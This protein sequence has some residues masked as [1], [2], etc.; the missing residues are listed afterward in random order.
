MKASLMMIALLL[1]SC[2]S[3]S[4]KRDVVLLS[5]IGTNDVHGGLDEQTGGL[6]AFSGY[7][8]ALRSQQDRVVVL[9][10]GGD[11][12]QGTLESNLNEGAAVMATYNALGYDAATI[13]NHEFD[14]GPVGDSAIPMS[15]RDDPRGALKARAA[16]A[17]FP[18][19][20]ANLIDASTQEPVDWPNV[21]P[22]QMLTK[23]GVRIGVIGITTAGT[24]TATI[25]ANTIGLLMAPLASTVER[26]AKALRAAG[27]DLVI[28]AA[29]AGG[30]CRAFDDPDDLSS[31]EAD[32]EIFELARVLPKGLVDQ[33]V[34]GH[35]HA[36]IAHI[37]NGVAI[38]S[39]RARLPSFGRVDYVL[40]KRTHQIL[41]RQVFPPQPVC[42]RWQEGS[43]TCAK[44]NDP[45][46]VAAAYEGIEIKALPA[47]TA[48]MADA[49]DFAKARKARRLGV[50]L[51][52]AFTRRGEPDAVIGHMMTDA[53]REATGADVAIHNVAGGIRADFEP[54]ELTFGDVYR[55]FPFDN[56]LAVLEL[57]GAELKRLLTHQ[58]HESGR[59]AGISGVRIE[60]VC[61]NGTMAL[62]LRKPDGNYVED[63]DKLRVAANDF[64]LL[65][66][67][68]IFK[69]I[70]PDEGYTIDFS[71]PRLRDVWVD[72]FEQR[73]GILRESD[74]HA[75][76]GSR[77]ALPQDYL[78]SCPR[79]D[80]SSH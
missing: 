79:P 13:G 6:A 64:L 56:L 20:A 34:A 25:S 58:V 73:G 3:L 48:A 57:N 16:E 44:G 4:P 75:S 62:S 74:F 22:S 63:D 29:H 41:S 54:G 19:L 27:A 35:H 67:G 53:I 2:T 37:V 77:W 1:A 76:G 39:N 49:I 51:E 47:V 78:T 40:D 10:D 9:L 5:I 46:T 36:G 66:G 11:M 55:V 72:W 24:L 80:N 65:G 45:S 28:V 14:F 52:T 43:R 61:A 8:H 42:R 68:R 60:V 21:S 30:S 71:Q 18:M 7:V 32:A 69:P 70:M 31:C 33:I 23:S 17:S 59:R 38:T 15:D 26:E 12:W 50:T